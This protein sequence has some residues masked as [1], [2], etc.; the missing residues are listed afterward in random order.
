MISLQMRCKKHHLSQVFSIRGLTF[1]KYIPRSPIL[2]NFGEDIY[3]LWSFTGQ[4]Y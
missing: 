3:V 1:E 4:Q 2:R